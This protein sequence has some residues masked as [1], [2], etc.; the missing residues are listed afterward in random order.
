[1]SQSPKE[2]VP[3]SVAIMT[4]SDSR[5]ATQDSSGDYFAGAITDAGHLVAERLICPDNRY[6]I[7]A[8]VSRWIAS[9]QVQVIIINGG[10]GFHQKNST[11]EAIEPLLDRT[12]EGFG[13][14]FRMISYEDIGAATLQSRAL[15]GLA[16]QTLIFALPGSTNA[17]SQAWERII[18][19]QIDARTRPCNFVSQLKKI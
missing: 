1:M 19:S 10:T 17:C 14:L 2:F 11:P 4:V 8:A 12:I 5:D 18:S 6:H 16:N 3:L 7:R 13:E 15:A 9:Q